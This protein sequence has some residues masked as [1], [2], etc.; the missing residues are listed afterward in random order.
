MECLLELLTILHGLATLTTNPVS[1]ASHRPP[2][3]VMFRVPAQLPFGRIGL[4]FD[5]LDLDPQDELL[6]KD[7]DESNNGSSTG[8]F[9][10]DD[11]L[12]LLFTNDTPSPSAGHDKPVAATGESRALEKLRQRREASEPTGESRALAVLRR[13][14]EECETRN[15]VDV[16]Y[17]TTQAPSPPTGEARAL[18]KLRQ[19]RLSEPS[20]DVDAEDDVTHPARRTRAP[21]QGLS[22]D[23]KQRRSSSRSHRSPS[24]RPAADGRAVEKTT[25]RKSGGRSS[26]AD[27]ERK[28]LV[29]SHSD[30]ER[31]RT[32]TRTSSSGRIKVGDVLTKSDGLAPPRRSSRSEKHPTTA[33]SSSSTAH[34][35]S[36]RKAIQGES[37]EDAHRQRHL[38]VRS[39]SV[40][41]QPVTS[42]ST[43]RQPQPQPQP[44]EPKNDRR[45]VC[46]SKSARL[47]DCSLQRRSSHGTLIRRRVVKRSDGGQEPSR[48]RAP[49]LTGQTASL[50]T[51]E[52]SNH[53]RVSSWYAADGGTLKD[54]VLAAVSSLDRGSSVQRTA[55]SRSVSLRGTKSS[56]PDANVQGASGEQTKTHDSSRVALRRVRSLDIGD[57]RPASILRNST[58]GEK[59]V[60]RSKS[61]S[62]HVS[63][64]RSETRRKS[65][66]VKG[67]SE[68]ARCLQE[69][70]PAKAK[71]VEKS[72]DLLRYLV[73]PPSRA[74]DDDDEVASMVS[75]LS[76]QSQSKSYKMVTKPLAKRESH[77]HPSSKPMPQSTD[78]G[79]DDGLEDDSSFASFGSSRSSRSN[80]C[81][82]MSVSKLVAERQVRSEREGAGKQASATTMFTLPSGLQSGQSRP[83]SGQEELD[84]GIRRYSLSDA[85]S[86]ASLRENI[87]LTNIHRRHSNDGSTHPGEHAMAGSNETNYRR[88]APPHASSTSMR[89]SSGH[90]RR[91][92]RDRLPTPAG[93]CVA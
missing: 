92:V 74:N 82:L 78:V 76:S 71:A 28:Q 57:D 7:A 87:R 18:A 42:N 89:A 93:V 8:E 45:L 23:P 11:A 24:N 58:R 48:A 59:G 84:S 70:A 6:G 66:S 5:E 79:E 40:P 56:V 46:R 3:T 65:S 41:R 37:S 26:G 88:Q 53:R 90:I 32:P 27:T 35:A 43:E 72:S 13:K 63:S 62:E 33:A 49:S 10:L 85:A 67:R 20:A 64:T 77:L 12:Q 61:N 51:A 17:G 54:D 69:D 80:K 81:T 75:E 22:S 15:D 50:L 91:S 1:F 2:Q 4:S 29:R 68:S 73:K 14:K 86:V 34:P 55:S 52:V 31:K 60:P 21:R 36:S 44:P 39:A 19:R 38:R 16:D 9:L 47:G 25:R 83:F 30:G